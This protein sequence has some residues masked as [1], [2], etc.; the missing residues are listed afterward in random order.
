[1]Q[2]KY[3]LFFDE[4]DKN[5]ITFVGGK[6]ANLGEMTKAGFQVPY[7]FCVTTKAY[8]DFLQYN[9]LLDFISKVIKDAS[10]ENISLVGEKIREKISKSEI[11]GDVAKEILNAVHK[12]GADKYYAVRSSA[13]AED[14]V[15]ASFAG[16]QDTYLNIRGDKS[17]DGVNSVLLSVRDCW[18]S[19][20]TDRAI[21]YRIQNKIEHENVYM[22]AVVQKMVFPEVA[23]IMFTADPVSG[24][25]GIISIDASYGLGE[26][27]VSGLVSPDIYKIRKINLQLDSKIIGD[28]KLAILPIQGGGTK[29]VDITV[30]KSKSQVMNDSQIIKLA[31]L[32]IKIE[33]HY[34]CPQDIEWCLEKNKLYIV[35]SRS[36]TSLDRKSVV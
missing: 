36:I 10:L 6:G 21:L 19:L 28:K 34:G 3:I 17:I 15:F 22:S 13:T 27:L 29:K 33:K 31:Q 14:L 8:K 30:E 11:P 1:M 12:T 35:Q 32:G 26:A 25:R 16:Q 5:D 23:G 4:I 24:Y 18:A 20:F 9:N 2:N 7:G